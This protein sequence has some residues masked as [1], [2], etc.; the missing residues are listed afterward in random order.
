MQYG[1]RARDMLLELK[2]CDF[3]PPYN[4]R[5][6][7]ISAH[8]FL[9]FLCV[10]S[11]V[12]FTSFRATYETILTF[13]IQESGIREITK[14]I[15]ML[16]KNIYDTLKIEKTKDISTMT[17]LTVFH[18]SLLRD[19]RLVLAYLYVM[20][21]LSLSVSVFDANSHRFT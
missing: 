5:L 18:Q 17:G 19:K 4:V 14:E 16:Y 10:L 3:L 7:L 13:R 8:F 15:N 9:V 1:Q 2:R 6:H 20:I 21:F 11:H 12:D